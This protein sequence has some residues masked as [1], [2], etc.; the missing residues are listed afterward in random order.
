NI[1]SIIRKWNGLL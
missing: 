1:G